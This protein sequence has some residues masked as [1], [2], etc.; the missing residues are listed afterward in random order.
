MEK[1]CILGL[2][3]IGLPTACLFATHGYQVV[4]VDKDKEK[5]RAIKQGIPPFEEAGIKA[6]GP[7]G[8]AAQLEADKAFAKQIMPLLLMG[9]IVMK[10]SS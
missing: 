4:G 2:G 3:Y 5:V 1:I 6:F 7:S 8:P 10:M 9:V